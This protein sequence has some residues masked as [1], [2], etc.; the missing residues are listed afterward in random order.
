[1]HVAPKQ[2]LQNQLKG[3]SSKVLSEVLLIVT[4]FMNREDLEVV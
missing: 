3:P 4:P 1:M 2:I